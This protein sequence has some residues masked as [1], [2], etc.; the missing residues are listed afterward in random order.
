MRDQ[1]DGKHIPAP[2]KI[3]I[4]PENVVQNVCGILINSV[5]VFRSKVKSM[6]DIESEP[7]TVSARFDMLREPSS[8]APTTMGSKGN[9][10]GASTVNIP[11]SMAIKKKII[12][13]YL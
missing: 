11:A 12:L 4:T 1:R 3:I 9:I 5:V 13:L 2:T 6:T 10:H 7:I 8:P